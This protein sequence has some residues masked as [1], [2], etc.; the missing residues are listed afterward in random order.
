[1][2]TY[3]SKGEMDGQLDGKGMGPLTIRM[4]DTLWLVVMLQP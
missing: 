3:I 1:M 2:Y 4:P